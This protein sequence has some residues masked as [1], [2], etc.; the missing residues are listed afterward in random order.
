MY[1]GWPSRQ[2]GHSLERILDGNGEG[3][4]K[5]TLTSHGEEAPREAGTVF[6]VKYR[7]WW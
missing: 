1:D 7:E 6:V 5:M 2:M 4:K 3:K